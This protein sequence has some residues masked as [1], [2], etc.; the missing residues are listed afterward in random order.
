MLTIL[1]TKEENLNYFNKAIKTLLCEAKQTNNQKG[2]LSK[3]RYRPKGLE[4]R[5]ELALIVSL[6]SSTTDSLPFI[7]WLYKYLYLYPEIRKLLFATG[8]KHYRKEQQIK[9]QNSAAQ[10]QWTHLQNAAIPQI[11]RTLWMRG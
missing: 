6:V 5:S 10:S 7:K 4:N 2:S 3:E 8:G 9:M 11:Q 1:Y